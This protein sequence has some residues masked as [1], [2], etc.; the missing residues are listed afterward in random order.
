MT[1]TELEINRFRVGGNSREIFS[2][3]EITVYSVSH[4]DC[5]ICPNDK[6]MDS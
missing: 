6:P 4:L 5:P 2:D 3:G 1:Y